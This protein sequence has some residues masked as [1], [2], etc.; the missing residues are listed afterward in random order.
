VAFE[1]PVLA[2]VKGVLAFVKGVL[3]FEKVVFAVSLAHITPDLQTPND[4]PM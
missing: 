2:F 3:A 1:N 4:L